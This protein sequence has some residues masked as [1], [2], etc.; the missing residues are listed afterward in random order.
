MEQEHDE[1]GESEGENVLIVEDE[2]SLAKLFAKQIG[3]EYDTTV[4]THAGNA[5]ANISVETDYVLLDRKL[6]GMSGD[7]VLEY[8]VSQP[9]DISVIIIS[10]IDPDQN[11]IHQPYDEYITKTVDD[12]E[13]KEAMERVEKKNRF[14]ELLGEYVKKAETW[15]VVQSNLSSAES[16]MDVDVGILEDD[17]DE[18]ADEF[19]TLAVELSDTKATDILSEIDIDELE[20]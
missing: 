18:L 5:I 20:S 7:K 11:V 15:E 14:V 4:V 2:E 6:P 8:I 12:G 16:D 13:I 1:S 17:L 3:D 10:A 19:A 9:Y